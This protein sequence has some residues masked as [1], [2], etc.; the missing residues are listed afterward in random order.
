[1]AAT[2]PPG[3]SPASHGAE[4]LVYGVVLTWNNFADTDE[5]LRSLREQDYG[6]FQTIVVDNGSRD[7][8]PARLRQAWHGRLE[9][10]SLSTRTTSSGGERPHRGR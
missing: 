9:F 7:G 1:M 2:D 5:C 8:S 3:L 6:R 4:C 10:V